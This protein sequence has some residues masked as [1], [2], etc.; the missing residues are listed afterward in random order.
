MYDTEMIEANKLIDDI[1]RDG[2]ATNL[3]RQQAEK[4]LLN[5]TARYND[6]KS[7]RETDR[8]EIDALQFQIAEN[9]AVGEYFS[10]LKTD[11][12]D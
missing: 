12:N 1:R 4:D 10:F 8:R 7:L 6:I 9:E 2:A 5:Q 3:K 11:L